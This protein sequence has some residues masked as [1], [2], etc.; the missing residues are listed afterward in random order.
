[1]P[2]SAYALLAVFTAIS[3]A[4]GWLAARVVGPPRPWA[5]VVP[6]LAAF[7]ALWLVGHRFVVRAGPTVELFGWQVSLPFDIAVALASAFAGAGAQRIGLRL[8]QSQQGGT[9]RDG[10]A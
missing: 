9:R 7:G 6:A 8:L 3:A 2:A 4:S 10:L 5:A 1:M